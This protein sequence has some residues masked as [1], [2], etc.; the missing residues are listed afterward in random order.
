MQTARSFKFELFHKEKQCGERGGGMKRFFKQFVVA[1]AFLG[2]LLWAATL[3]PG[4]SSRGYGLVLP[5]V[6]LLLL[7]LLTTVFFNWALKIEI[8]GKTT[9]IEQELLRSRTLYSDNLEKERL[10]N[11]YFL[12]L[13]HELRTP[14]HVILAAMQSMENGGGIQELARNPEKAQWT[15]DV[16]KTNSF[17]LLRCISNL[18]DIMHLD[19]NIYPLRLEMMEI[20]ESINSV[21]QEVRPYFDKKRI[22]LVYSNEDVDTRTV[23]DVEV[24]ERILLNLLSNALKFTPKNGIVSLR[25]VRDIVT[26]DISMSIQDTG[27]GIPDADKERIFEKFVQLQADLVR[28][29]EGNGLGLALSSR[30]AKRLGGRIEV[31]SPEQGGAEFR[32][33]LPVVQQNPAERTEPTM[34]VHRE[35]LK[36]RVLVEF[37]DILDE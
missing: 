13:S 15:C 29:H 36:Q 16:I 2:V 27:P 4:L 19:D 35:S 7:A 8:Q 37:S 30:F 12:T 9:F 10:K 26:G 28:E 14:L 6:G 22:R 32:L 3:L 25:T 24:F 33:R 11:S 20:R 23:S 34:A 17:R 1:A 21:I 5:I 18:I 31:V